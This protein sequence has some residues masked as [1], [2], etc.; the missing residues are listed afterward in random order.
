MNESSPHKQP[1]APLNSSQEPSAAES[2]PAQKQRIRRETDQGVPA[3]AVRGVGASAANAM[4][5]RR[6]AHNNHRL[7]SPFLAVAM[8]V[9]A[10]VIWQCKTTT[11]EAGTALWA[12][13]L[14]AAAIVYFGLLWGGR[15]AYQSGIASPWVIAIHSALLVA[16]ALYGFGAAA[17]ALG[18]SANDLRLL[19]LT[20]LL[21]CVT[22]F[23]A[24]VALETVFR[25]FVALS[26]LPLLA[27]LLSHSP[28]DL[29][30]N[31]VLAVATILLLVGH[32]GLARTLRNAFRADVEQRALL[33]RLEHANQALSADRMVL[34]TETRTDPLTGL[35]NRRY[36]EQ[37]L[38]AEWNRCRRS[39]VPLSCVM[40]DIDHFKA[41]N[42][43]Y[44]HDGGDRCLKAVANILNNSTRRASDLV[45]RY[46][47]EEFVLLLPETGDIGATTVADLLKT[48][49]IDARIEHLASP[50]TGILTLSLGV[51]TLLPDSDRMP[52][53]LLKAADLALYEAKRIGRNRVVQADGQALEAARLTAR[54]LIG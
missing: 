1:V 8:L 47:G 11:L 16:A 28:A 44:G 26:V 29:A 14:G 23:A 4:Q 22:A 5:I 43:H 38:A 3:A 24:L 42:D 20:T 45:A 7:L 30:L 6:R 41:Y 39:E 17:T 9:A 37:T 10:W 52:D 33:Q 50:L 19:A 25:A 54:G 13:L 18:A 31:V 27:A 35:A 21:V 51:A 2:A 46:G 12:G 53:E 34:Q 15:K 36:L 40:L 49:V 48:A 32:A